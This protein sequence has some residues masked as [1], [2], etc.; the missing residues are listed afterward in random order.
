MNPAGGFLA[1]VKF[2]LLAVF[3]GRSEA[4]MARFRFRRMWQR[5]VD[6]PPEQSSRNTVAHS[7]KQVVV[8]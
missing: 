2:G 1:F 7:P 6:D 3:A 5:W 4:E 8:M